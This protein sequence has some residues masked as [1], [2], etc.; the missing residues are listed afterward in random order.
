[1]DNQTVEMNMT[2]IIHIH[3][4]RAH[5]YDFVIPINELAARQ[6]IASKHGYQIDSRVIVQKIKDKK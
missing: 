5:S 2:C 3:P 1:M 4:F 6:V